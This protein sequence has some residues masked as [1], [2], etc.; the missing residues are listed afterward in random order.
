MTEFDDIQ[1]RLEDAIAR[2]AELLTQYGS[3][4]CSPAEIAHVVL[5][6]E[7][8]FL[9]LAVNRQAKTVDDIAEQ[10]LAGN[11]LLEAILDHIQSLD[12]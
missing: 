12:V 3:Q 10:V 4:S 11:R 2:S 1:E 9:T 6:R 8:A 7:I 5:A